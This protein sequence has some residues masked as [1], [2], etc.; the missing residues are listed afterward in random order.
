MSEGSIVATFLVVFREG[1]EASLVVGIILTV[2]ARLKQSR[3]FSVVIWSSVAACAASVAAGMAL[4]VLTHQV[5]GRM[6][7]WLEGSISLLACGVLTYMVF[8]MDR[9][10][11]RIR[12]EIEAKIEQ[13]VSRG[14][15]VAIAIMTFLAIFREGAETV[16]FLKAVAAQSS[17]YV[18]L[19]GGL[20]G[21][22]M[23]VL[24]VALIFAGG[25]RIPLRPL[26]RGSGI[27]LLLVAGGLLAY[28][29]HEFHE[30]GVL[31]E[32][33]APVWN[34]NPILNEKEGLGAFLKA[35]FGYDG[36]PS[37]LEVLAYAGYL[38]GVSYLLFGRRPKVPGRVS[39]AVSSTSPK[40]FPAGRH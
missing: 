28:G 20:A 25:K 39:T 23:A 35:L 24:L 18:S 32:I 5:R 34:L 37:L 15:L 12:P 4:A 22:L 9:Q 30:L 14:E 38:G 6:E 31:P 10:A 7:Q 27:F 8:W 17:G 3:Y 19:G 40:A 26:F 29:I 33:Y 11:K 21:L 1:L 2:L 16:L 13:A 36:N